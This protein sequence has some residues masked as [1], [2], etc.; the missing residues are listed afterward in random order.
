MGNAE[1][2]ECS[3][4][5]IKTPAPLIRTYYIR[6]SEYNHPTTYTASPPSRYLALLSAVNTHPHPNLRANDE[7]PI[8]IKPFRPLVK[9]HVTV[10]V[11]ADG[12]SCTKMSTDTGGGIEALELT[13]H[14]LGL[15]QSNDLPT[16]QLIGNP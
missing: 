16:L 11:P 4:V 9:A 12:Y 2:L 13:A 14:Q 15:E 5:Y 1:S 7:L 8:W 3:V 10:Q 6:T